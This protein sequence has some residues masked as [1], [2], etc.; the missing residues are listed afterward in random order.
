MRVSQTLHVSDQL[1]EAEEGFTRE[2][3]RRQQESADADATHAGA[4]GVQMSVFA[5]PLASFFSYFQKENSG[6]VIFL[7][8]VFLSSQKNPSDMSYSH[9]KINILLLSSICLVYMLKLKNNDNRGYL[10]RMESGPFPR[11]HPCVLLSGRRS[12]LLRPPEFADC[13]SAVEMLL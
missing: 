3:G 11:V 13:F 12:R 8:F 2:G 5:S 7:G 6:N 10:S 4:S 1:P 9:R